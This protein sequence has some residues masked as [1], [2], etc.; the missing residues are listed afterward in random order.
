VA[1]G[2]DAEVDGFHAAGG[3]GVGLGEF[4]GGGG[5]AD[6]ESSGF[7]GPAFAFGF[8]DAGEEVVADFLEAVP[9]PLF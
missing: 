1:V 3:G 5:E 7:S 6:S 9:S 4:V 8:G 2:G